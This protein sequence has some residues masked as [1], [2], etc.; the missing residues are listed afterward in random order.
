MDQFPILKQKREWF[1]T[2]IRKKNL[3][4][5][6]NKKRVFSVNEDFQKP[7]Y[8][9]LVN[10]FN[11]DMVGSLQRIIILLNDK[12]ILCMVE[13]NIAGII[14]ERCLNIREAQSWDFFK[15]CLKYV[16]LLSRLEHKYLSPYL[17]QFNG[18]Q[19][20]I[21]CF[22]D[23][24]TWIKQVEIL[25]KGNDDNN[26]LSN[27]LS[28]EDRLSYTYNMLIQIITLITQDCDDQREILLKDM[29][30]LECLFKVAQIR[31]D[32]AVLVSSLNLFG[33]ILT[34]LKEQKDTKLLQKVAS[35]IR[36]LCQA[37]RTPNV[38]KKNA[39]LYVLLQ[40][41]KV[42]VEFAMSYTLIKH[43]LV[44][45][46]M[47][48]LMNN[49]HVQIDIYCMKIMYELVQQTQTYTKLLYDK[50]FMEVIR[51]KIYQDQQ[52]ILSNLLYLFANLVEYQKDMDKEV[53]IDKRIII[54]LIDIVHYF[55]VEARDEALFTLCAII[56]ISNID[57]L[58][59]LCDLKVNYLLVDYIG[60]IQ[61]QELQEHIMRIKRVTNSVQ[62]QDK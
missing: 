6:F 59:V 19:G 41:S 12:P 8:L 26:P 62:S 33:Q 28:V 35:M 25:I 52:N 16:G 61:N 37:L 10:Q 1:H 22:L 21:Q 44:E 3:Q 29:V 42:N 55:E 14:M 54:R 57:Q 53:F 27:G 51:K 23:T 38:I 5:I 39:I 20:L 32:Q 36:P 46:L 4:D 18:L 60:S 11:Y 7:E 48:T 2:Q 47:T 58:M 56:K 43:N 40:F 49:N 45:T 9:E 13:N 30:F 34:D 15:D 31:Q 50:G 17:R 24:V